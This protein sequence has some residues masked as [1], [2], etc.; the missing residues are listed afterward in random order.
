[1]FRRCVRLD[2]LKKELRSDKLRESGQ[3]NSRKLRDFKLQSASVVHDQ[4]PLE[5]HA[6]AVRSKFRPI[7]EE[8]G[9]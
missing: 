3:S 2:K 8:A 1:M 5:P 6:Y 4:K 7:V 9:I